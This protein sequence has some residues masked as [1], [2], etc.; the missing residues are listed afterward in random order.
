M[1]AY[2]PYITVTVSGMKKYCSIVRFIIKAA[3]E[4]FESSIAPCSATNN[5]LE[6]V[7]SN[8]TDQRKLISENEIQKKILFLSL[9]R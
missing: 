6:I 2:I 8:K 4:L 7:C 5:I 1:I 9:R 3:G